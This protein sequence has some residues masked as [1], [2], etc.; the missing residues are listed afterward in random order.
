MSFWGVL[1]ADIWLLEV[2]GG[3]GGT[4]YLSTFV[5]LN[6]F[7]YYFVWI[8]LYE[9]FVWKSLY[10]YFVWKFL[11]D[12]FVWKSLNGGNVTGARQ[13]HDTA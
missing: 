5:A 9:H 8:S 11:Y 12:H 10:G 1:P 4:Q 6:P 7:M 13:E 3:I 2:E